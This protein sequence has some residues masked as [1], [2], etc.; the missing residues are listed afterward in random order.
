MMI[1]PDGFVQALADGTRL[2]A[3]VLLRCEEWLCVCELTAA[4][5]VSQPKMSRHLAALRAL[6]LVDDARIANRVFYRLHPEL[7][8]WARDVLERLAE[9]L[10]NTTADLATARH[11]LDRFPNRPLQ[12]PGFSPADAAVDRGEIGHAV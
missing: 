9:G 1:D 6:G 5:D 7:P 4:L 2:R 8:Q 12:R 10:M 11:R 3:L